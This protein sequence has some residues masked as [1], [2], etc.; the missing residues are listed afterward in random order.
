MLLDKSFSL[1]K[2]LSLSLIIFVLSAPSSA[3]K[4]KGSMDCK[5]LETSVMEVK[6]GRA[7]IYSGVEGFL[8]KGDSF[9]F[10]YKYLGSPNELGV[11]IE[12]SVDNHR[13]MRLFLLQP[14]GFHSK[15]ISYFNTSS[16]LSYLDDGGTRFLSFGPNYIR[17]VTEYD[18]EVRLQRYYKDDWHGI[19]RKT[20]GFLVQ[21]HAFNCQPDAVKITKLIE[22]FKKAASENDKLID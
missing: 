3:E 1:R 9:K 16:N 6:E 19:I 10:V 13:G 17:I 20:D 21:T 7:Y 8:S 22:V 11:D 18:E 14:I 12:F 5:I 4:I 2:F 15:Q